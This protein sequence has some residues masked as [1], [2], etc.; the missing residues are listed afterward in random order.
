MMIKQ[1]LFHHID[2]FDICLFFVYFSDKNSVR[3]AMQRSMLWA[4]PKRV[5]PH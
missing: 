5:L 3:A 4:E 1:L 2:I